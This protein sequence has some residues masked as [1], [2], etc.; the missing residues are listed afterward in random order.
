MSTTVVSQPTGTQYPT[1]SIQNNILALL[2]NLP[3]ETLILVEQFVRFVY[4]QDRQGRS[5][6][7]ALK[8]KVP[9]YQY[10]TVALPASS[11]SAWLNLLPEG[12]E[13]DALANTEALYDEV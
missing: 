3:P 1:S 8:E 11:L 12:Y 6:V 5:V 4:E 13:G 10:P 2:A 9:P 7:I